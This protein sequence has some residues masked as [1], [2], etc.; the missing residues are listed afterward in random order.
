MKYILTTTI[1]LLSVITLGQEKIVD[2]IISHH[3]DLKTIEG[4]FAEQKVMPQL[5]EP[6]TSTGV[7]Y[8]KN[9]KMRWEQQNPQ[10]HIIVVNDQTMSVKENGK[11]SSYN[12][13]GNR[14]MK[15]VSEIMLKL[16]DGSYLKDKDFERKI[17]TH[18][19]SWEIHLTPKSK[20]MK[21]IMQQIKL[22][23]DKQTKNLTTFT[24][25]ESAT[26]YTKVKLFV[27]KENQEISD[28]KFEL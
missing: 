3:K 15:M 22:V 4:T 10:S 24:I 18:K 6:L 12:L 1:L 17:I 5:K 23:F 8:I 21:N 7:F 16:A 13:K 20:A 28:S 19:D 27:K 25:V 11:V 2:E 9:E 14:K 26:V